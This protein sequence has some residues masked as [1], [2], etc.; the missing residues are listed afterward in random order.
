LADLE[1]GQTLEK[2]DM[3][4]CRWFKRGWTL[5]ELIAPET[6]TI[7]D[8]NWNR[9]G[10]RSDKSI[11]KSLADITGVDQKILILA[12]STSRY[13]E[14]KVIWKDDLRQALDAVPIGLRMRWASLRHTTRLEDSAY[15]LLGVFNVQIPLL[16]GEGT[17]AFRR[18]QEEIIK[19]STDMTIFGWKAPPDAPRYSGIFADS[20]AHFADDGDTGLV[21]G[22]LAT[23]SE[24]TLT[25]RGLRLPLNAIN[26]YSMG[27]LNLPSV[28][29]QAF[30]MSVSYSPS[31]MA[32][33]LVVLKRMQKDMFCRDN[34][35]SRGLLQSG[36]WENEPP[37]K[38]PEPV[39]VTYHRESAVAV[40]RFDQLDGQSR[41]IFEP[42]LEL[43]QTMPQLCWDPL[44]STILNEFNKAT[45]V[46]KYE[47]LDAKTLHFVIFISGLTYWGGH[48]AIYVMDFTSPAAQYCLDGNQ[49]GRRSS[50]K[51]LWNVEPARKLADLPKKTLSSS[52]STP[53]GREKLSIQITVDYSKTSKTRTFEISCELIEEKE[54]LLDRMLK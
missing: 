46:F 31:R 18:L 44:H 36:F 11:A 6:L 16:Y 1:E 52:I 14:S 29:G 37:F 54:S 39:Y 34:Y 30:C 43:I 48:E 24:F 22:D 13:L 25:N 41:L 32:R 5:Q 45:L 35:K 27:R 47:R 15:S 51:D 20:V 4:N 21:A 19:T 26:V 10:E 3:V 42:P 7:F 40:S 17:H 23:S 38:E 53:H 28:E 49:L 9:R 33:S 50:L 8:H 2:D 12:E